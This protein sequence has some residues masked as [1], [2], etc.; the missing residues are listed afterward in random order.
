[1]FGQPTQVTVARCEL[2]PGVANP[3][4]RLAIEHARCMALV[5]HPAAVNESVR[6]LACEPLVASQPVGALRVAGLFAV[7]RHACL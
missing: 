6:V 1:M 5:L 4:D 2:G 7:V 3:D